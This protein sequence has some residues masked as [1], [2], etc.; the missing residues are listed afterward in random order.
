MKLTLQSSYITWPRAAK[1]TWKGG[2]DDK[3]S[4]QGK[5]RKQKIGKITERQKSMNMTITSNIIITGADV[6]C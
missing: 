4:C 3:R 1:E 5:S 6:E 2:Q